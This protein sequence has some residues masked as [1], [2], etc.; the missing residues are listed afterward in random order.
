[1]PLAIAGLVPTEGLNAAR[2]AYIDMEADGSGRLTESVSGASLDIYG[3]FVP[4][5]IPGAVGKALRFDG[6]TTYVS[7]DLGQIG[8][9]DI[10]AM[11]VSL[12]IAPETYPIVEVDVATTKKIVVAGTIDND[13]K[14]VGRCRSAITVIIRLTSIATACPAQCRPMTNCRLMNG[15]M[16]WS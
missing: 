4:E 6:Y 11:T 13:A 8:A 15:V 1:M 7:G 10:E 9:S 2:I 3:N 5:N 12:W 16:S 14:K